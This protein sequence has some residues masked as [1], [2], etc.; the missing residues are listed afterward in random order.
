MPWAEISLSLDREHV[1]LAEEVLTTHGALAVTLLDDAGEAVLE[2][3]PG[4]VS[5]WPVV[6]LRALFTEDAN[7]AEV[8]DDLLRLPGIERPDAAA[9]R[10]VEDRNWESA[11]LDRFEPM[12]FGA[13][14]WIVPTGMQ[15]P[16]D[17][18]AC[19]LHQDPGLGF[20][21]GRHPTTALCLEWI[22]GQ[23]FAGRR[24]VDYG[25]GSG[26]LGIAAAL[27]GARAVSCVDHDPQA[28][29]ATADHAGRNGVA[30]RITCLAPEQF[31]RQPVDVVLANILA[32]PLIELA[33]RLSGVLAPGARIVLSGVLAA[34]AAAVAAA[35]RPFV[36]GLARCE[37]EGWVR[38]DGVAPGADA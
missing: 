17:P 11:W 34:Q 18:L 23:D 28:L 26:V 27:K 25:C 38:L 21:T 36:V 3:A 14:L 29:I 15:A 16:D 10:R 37:R 20:G 7:R 12:R 5:L 22:D 1:P 13:H 31:P 19:V 24:V 2:P 8:L 30:D 35:Y 4:A 33:P 6:E 9:W 32:E